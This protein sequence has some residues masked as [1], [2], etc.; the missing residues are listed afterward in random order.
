M[1]SGKKH[2]L[3]RRQDRRQDQDPWP[4]PRRRLFPKPGGQFQPRIG[5]RVWLTALFMLVTAFAGITAYEIVRPILIN[6][7]E[8]SS[9]AYFAQVGN[10]Y[11]ELLQRNGGS[12]TQQRI[13]AFAS[14]QGL[15][16][17]IVRAPDQR[18]LQGSDNLEWNPRV[19]RRAANT[20]DPKRAIELIE[21]GPRE[22]QQL[23][24]Y[25]APLGVPG[26]EDT[27]V[28][29][30]RYFLE[31]EL[32]A[33]ADIRGINRIVFLAG[34]L[35]LLITGFA[36]Y[37][38]ATLIS[39]RISRLGLAAERLAEGNFEERIR[40][41]IEDEVGSLGNTF[42]SMA[43]SLQGAFR[44]VEQEK[45]RGR[46]IL[47]GMTDAVV[48][49]NKDLNT[50]F[51]NPRARKLLNSSDRSFRGRLQEILTRAGR[52]GP[53]T[54]SA[55]EA[56]NRLIEV[57]AAPIEEGALAILR[58]VTEEQ[59]VQRVKAEF[60]ATASHELKTPLFALSG[61][62]ELMEDEESEEVRVGFLDEMRVQTE[63]LQN[64]A[65][66]LLDLSRLD[67]NAMTFRLEEV[68]LEDMLHTLRRDFSYTGRPVNIHTEEDVPPVETDPTQLH[69]MLAIL[70]D[71]ALK[72]SDEDSPVDLNLSRENGHAVV[73]V[74]DQGCGIPE[75]ELPYIFDRFYRVQGSSRADGTGLG[76]A[77]ANEITDHLGGE[78]QVQSKPDAGSVFSV[79]LPISE[80]TDE[81]QDNRAG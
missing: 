17:G 7:L 12:I 35:A 76:L 79:V 48:G 38:V 66:T 8:R 15:Q 36:G 5:I 34:I 29:F 20:G 33:A 25:A 67:A 54:E 50:I 73:S 19:V 18:K 68:Y 71:N 57:R 49:V 55:V 2:V 72:Y 32:N 21:T 13:R 70:L 9:E 62:L 78:I 27:T 37:V 59:R 61:Y 44:Q 16:W 60:I 31:S 39:R 53:V 28:V 45:E 3:R 56:G 52:D 22:G 24:T 64:L 10:Q 77:L 58:D 65:R 14:T 69:R 40:T 26:E 23:A 4:R 42:N 81:P 1:F 80:N 43:V 30:T 51:L 11:E 46:A 63:R 74:K 6:T 75:E 47:D 41:R